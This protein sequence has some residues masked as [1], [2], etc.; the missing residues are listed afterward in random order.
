MAALPAFA[1]RRAAARTCS[2]G[3]PVTVCH[4]LG[5]A[6]RMRDERLPLLVRRPL[7]ALRDVALVRQPFRHDDVRQRIDHR[8]VRARPQLQVIVRLDVRRAHDADLA[9]IDDDELRAL[10]QPPLHLRGEH[11]MTLG[12]IR[13]DEHD[14]IGLHDGHERLRAGRL[15]QRVL[16][17]VAGR[18]MAHARAGID[19][20][21]AERRA[22]QLL[23]EIRLFVRAARRGDA[24]DRIACRTSPECA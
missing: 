12:R 13:A 20:V 1:Y 18:R 21:V 15:A 7:A 4:R 11:R 6:I 16:Q 17:A 22:H 8:D 14:H 19:V 9:R 3:T 10:S 5:R 24:A 23:H 2:A